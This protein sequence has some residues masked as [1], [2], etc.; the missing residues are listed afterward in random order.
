M[1]Q[2]AHLY[3]SSVLPSVRPGGDPAT[4]IRLCDAHREILEHPTEELIV[5]QLHRIDSDVVAQLDHDELVLLVA[6]TEHVPVLLGGQNGR[7]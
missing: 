1:E 2:K 4:R 6:R 3:T 5:R 7:R